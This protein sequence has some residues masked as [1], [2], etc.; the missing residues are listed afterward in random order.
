MSKNDPQKRKKNEKFMVRNFFIFFKKQE[1]YA[2][3]SEKMRFFAQ[4]LTSFS[5]LDIYKCPKRLF[6]FKIW[7][8]FVIENF[9]WIYLIYF[10]MYYA[11]CI[12]NIFPLGVYILNN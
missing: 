6:V 2:A 7:K 9:N 4:K 8:K 10:V 1:H 11:L 3:K 5:K 12:I